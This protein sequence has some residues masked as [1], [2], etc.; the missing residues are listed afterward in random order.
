MVL[1]RGVVR[2]E[3]TTARKNLLNFNHDDDGENVGFIV[4]LRL[5]V[6]VIHIAATTKLW[7]WFGC[8]PIKKGILAWVANFHSN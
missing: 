4:G 1:S 2:E 6:M 8:I 7:V 5:A 3:L